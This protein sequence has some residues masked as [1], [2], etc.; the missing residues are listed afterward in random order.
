MMRRVS[1]ASF[2]VLIAVISVFFFRPSEKEPNHVSG[3]FDALNYWNQQRAYPNEIIPDVGHYAAFE[4]TKSNMGAGAEA[5]SNVD[6]WETMGPTNIGGRALALAF[7][8][9]K[10][11]P[12]WV[13]TASGGHWVSRPGGVGYVA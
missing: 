11:N 8:P 2:L 5:L 1:I 9:K 12:I 10:P 6:Q 3:A 4:A 13:G 7:T